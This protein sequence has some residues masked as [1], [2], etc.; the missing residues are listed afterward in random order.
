MIAS[1]PMMSILYLPVRLTRAPDTIEPRMR[2]ASS[3]SVWRPDS[4]GLISLTVWNQSGR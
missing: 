2:P 3:A 1:E 4:V